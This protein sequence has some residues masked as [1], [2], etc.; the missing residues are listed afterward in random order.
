MYTNG[1]H[2]CMCL[3]CNGVQDYI[4]LSTIYIHDY[5]CLSINGA[6]DYTYLSAK[7]THD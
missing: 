1:A 4:H 2:D 3:C 6:R 5:T 7:D